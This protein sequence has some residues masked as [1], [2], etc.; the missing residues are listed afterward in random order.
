MATVNNVLD[1][2]RAQ[3]LT[4]SN[5]LTNAKGI[6]FTNE[7]LGDFHRRLIKAGVDASQIQEAYQNG[8]ANIGTYLYPSDALFLKAIEL[9]YGDTSAQNYVTASQIDVSNIPGGQ[10]F[11][12]LRSNADINQPLFDDHGDWFEIFPTP[13]SANNLT[14]MMRIFYYLK[15]TEYT[16]VSD[17]VAYPPS[18]DYRTFGWRVAANYLKSLGQI[19]QAQV[20]INEYEQRV[21]DYIAFLSRGAQQPLQATGIALT[22]WEF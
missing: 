17:T 7:A 19:D 13:T 12:W 5:G 3:A 18:M 10:S 8:T 2:A 20:F 21:K 9:N 16:A 15:P 11:S 6:I 1:F 14:N 4:D 22:G